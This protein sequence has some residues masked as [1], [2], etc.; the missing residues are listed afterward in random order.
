MNTAVSGV[1]FALRS[2]EPSLGFCIYSCNYGT[3]AWRGQNGRLKT[4][5]AKFTALILLHIT[6]ETY[7]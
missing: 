7:L 1:L 2:S 4:L 3:G 5:W 6:Y